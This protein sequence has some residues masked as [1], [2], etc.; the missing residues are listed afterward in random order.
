MDIGVTQHFAIVQGNHLAELE[1]FANI[2][3]FTFH[4]I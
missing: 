4:R 3:N 1:A 2:M